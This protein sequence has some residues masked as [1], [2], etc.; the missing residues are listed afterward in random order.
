MDLCRSSYQGSLDVL[1]LAGLAVLL[2]ASPG[3]QCGGL[4]GAAKGEREGPGP[5]Q[6]TLV[7]GIQVYG[8]LLFAL[9]AGQEGHPWGGRERRFRW[10]HG[11][12]V[13]TRSRRQRV[14]LTWHGGG[15]GAPQGGHSCQGDLLRGVLFGAGVS[16]GHHVGF[17]QRALQVDVVVGKRLVDGRQHLRE[18]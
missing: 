13:S 18:K 15:H 14:R 1:V 9:T 16:G 7:D 11:R 10:K 6:G 5:V 17:E 8:G 4:Q 3:L 12:R 2:L